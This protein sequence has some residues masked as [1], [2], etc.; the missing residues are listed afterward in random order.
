MV[1]WWVKIAILNKMVREGLTFKQRPEGGRGTTHGDSWGQGFQKKSKSKGP[2]V[3]VCLGCS[4]ASE[5]AC[6]T[7]VK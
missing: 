7:G 4:G 2:T 1:K 3:K 5:E 6:E